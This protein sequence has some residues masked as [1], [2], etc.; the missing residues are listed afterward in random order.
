MFFFFFTT[1]TKDINNVFSLCV[2][3]SCKGQYIYTYVKFSFYHSF[4]RIASLA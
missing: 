2:L 4:I 3:I 1:F